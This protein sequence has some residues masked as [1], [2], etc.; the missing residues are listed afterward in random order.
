MAEIKILRILMN[1][2]LPEIH[3]IV[4]Q[5][6]TFVKQVYAAVSKGHATSF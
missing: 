2:L 1:K 3:F 5:H 4:N 6:D